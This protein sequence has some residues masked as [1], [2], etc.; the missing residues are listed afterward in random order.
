MAS[1]L[2]KALIET[3]LEIL[4][5]MVRKVQPMIGGYSANGKEVFSQWQDGGKC[6]IVGIR[7]V[8]LDISFAILEGLCTKIDTFGSSNSQ[9]SSRLLVSYDLR[10]RSLPIL[11]VAEALFREMSSVFEQMNMIASSL[12]S[13]SNS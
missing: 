8:I 10:N 1:D 13:R 11:R 7:S 6:H 4:I 2:V 12:L 5:Q 9:C 3:C